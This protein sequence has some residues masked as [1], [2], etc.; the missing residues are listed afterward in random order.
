MA[1]P[2]YATSPICTLITGTDATPSTK[3]IGATYAGLVAR[4]AS[5][6]PPRIP[7]NPPSVDIEVR[8]NHVNKALSTLPA[9]RTE[10]PDLLGGTNLRERDPLD[11]DLVSDGVDNTAWRVHER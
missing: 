3:P 10:I 8:P 1:Q 2:E 6:V 4:P 7:L 11:S 5:H 9:R